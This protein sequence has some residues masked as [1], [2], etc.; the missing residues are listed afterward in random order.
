MFL[1]FVF[2]VIVEAFMQIR[3]IKKHKDKTITHMVHK[4]LTWFGQ[5]CPVMKKSKNIAKISIILNIRGGRNEIGHRLSIRGFSAKNRKYRQYITDI[6][7]KTQNFV[8]K[9]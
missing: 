6:L 7:L 1:Y 9:S 3:L 4:V 5:P 2:V 8:E